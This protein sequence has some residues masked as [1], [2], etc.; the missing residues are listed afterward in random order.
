TCECVM[1]HLA[2][3]ETETAHMLFEWV[4]QYRVDSGR[5]WTGTVY[6][7]LSHFPDGEQ[8]TYTAGAVVL[9]ADALAGTGAASGLF[10]RHDDMFRPLLEIDELADPGS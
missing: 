1:A 7:D 10:T 3:G 8:S 5:Y 6:P 2:V 4:Q 9:A